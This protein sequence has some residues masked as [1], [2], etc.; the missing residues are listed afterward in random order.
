MRAER[1]QKQI[2]LEAATL[3]T[4]GKVAEAVRVVR[5]GE[6][7]SLK[8]ARQRIDAHIAGDPMLGVQLETQRRAFRRKLFYVFLVVDAL[9]VAGAI[10][11][12][13]FMPR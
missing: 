13:F 3:L 12:F 10:Y 4:E 7:V 1:R 2:S 6:G 8:E 11:F 9:I 5:D